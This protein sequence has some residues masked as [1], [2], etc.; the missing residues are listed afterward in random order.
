MSP[1]ANALLGLLFLVAGLFATLLMYYLR[2]ST[3]RRQERP[4]SGG[5][6]SSDAIGDPAEGDYL[7]Q[8]KRTDDQREPYL[9]EIH[10][11]AETG[12]SIIEPMRT[13]KK[14]PTWD[15]L[16]IKGAQLATL[17]LNEDEP[18]QTETVLGPGADK[19]LVIDTPMIVSHMSYGALSRE[20][21]TALAKGSAAVGTAICSGEGGMLEEEFAHAHRYILEYV[22]NQYSI[23]DENLCRVDAIEIKIG[24]SA[25]AGM[26][27]HLPGGKVTEEIAA[28]RGRE[29][30]RDIVSP[31]R[32]PGV[33]TAQDL[34]GLV[35][36]LRERAAGRP[37][38]VKIAAGNLEPDLEFALAA[39][40]DFIT[41]DGRA[42][43]TGAAPKVVKDAVSVPTIHALCRARAL[44][45]QHRVKHVS[46]IITG[47]MRVSADFAK[48]LALG[49]DAVA[50]ATAALIASGCQQYRICNTGN[51]P[52][53]IATQDPQLRRRLHVDL[54]ARYLENFLRVCTEELKTFARLTGHRNIH[55]I[56]VHDLCTTNSELSNTTVIEHV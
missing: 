52:V 22:P 48:A 47:G 39:G 18:V 46:L 12:R 56:S 54:S 55:G 2:G 19:P 3:S 27:G 49:A 34:R 41:L 23:T 33:Q 14:T 21:K 11:I 17:P 10:T 36:S 25:K 30:G 31:A 37:V 1:L 24:Q 50:I 26:G 38:G 20:I 45:D 9:D 51:C 28:V 44:L 29:V 6:V 15:D 40:P 5:T 42:G 35:D 7:A 32:F 4:A 43:A 53:G 13:A 8:W 16:L